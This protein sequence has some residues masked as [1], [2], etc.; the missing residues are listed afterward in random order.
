MILVWIDRLLNVMEKIIR[1][2]TLNFHTHT[3][4]GHAH[5]PPRAHEHQYEEKHTYHEFSLSPRPLIVGMIRGLAGSA[6]LKLLVIPTI[7]SC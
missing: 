4:G 1:G 5:A 6:A 7:D 2:G 3:H